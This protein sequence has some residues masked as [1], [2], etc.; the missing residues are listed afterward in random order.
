MEIEIL[1]QISGTPAL[2]LSIMIAIADSMKSTGDEETF[3]HDLLDKL[4]RLPVSIKGKYNFVSMVVTRAGAKVLLQKH[5]NF[6]CQIK[7]LLAVNHM[8]PVISKTYRTI[9]ADVAARKDDRFWEETL[10]PGLAMAIL[11]GNLHVRS[12]AVLYWLPIHLKSF[13]DSYHKILDKIQGDATKHRVNAEIK[14]LALMATSKFAR[15]ENK[16]SFADLDYNLICSG[17]SHFN[18]SKNTVLKRNTL[19]DELCFKQ[20]AV[21]SEA[22]QIVCCHT[23]S[24]ERI[25]K[26]E[27]ELIKSFLP[28]NMNC[29]SVVFRQQLEYCVR[30]LAERIRDSVYPSKRAKSKLEV[31]VSQISSPTS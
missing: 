3:L 14:Y 2:A 12:N 20:D 23:K 15:K 1:F 28:L 4:M 13:R 8:W 10:L 5:P 17:L 18:V 16:L 24:S 19:H 29:D 6:L 22:F 26:Q 7:P 31:C 9:V 11:D 27:M 25:S 30:C 21:R